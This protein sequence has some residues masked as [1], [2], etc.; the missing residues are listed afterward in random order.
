MHSSEGYLFDR[1]YL[2]YVLAAM[3]PQGFKLHVSAT[4]QNAA[5]IAGIVLPVLR[6]MRVNHKVVRSVEEYAT[7]VTGTQRGKF[8]TIFPES[9]QQAAA[10]AKKIDSL[11]LEYCYG[12]NDFWAVQNEKP[13]GTTGAISTRYGQFT[14][15]YPGLIKPDGSVVPDL[16]GVAWKPDWV[17]DPFE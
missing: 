17:S 6:E 9:D 4:D 16:R 10:I 5:E 12:K 13:L 2:V 3:R 1:I 14:N 8:I 11:L 15:E 7:L